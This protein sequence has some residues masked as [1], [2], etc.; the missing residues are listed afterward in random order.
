MDGVNGEQVSEQQSMERMKVLLAEPPAEESKR[1]VEEL[2]ENSLYGVFRASLDG[3]LLTA[4]PAM[5]Q[6]LAYPVLDELQAASLPREI[7]RFPA[8]F[9][10]LVALCRDNGIVP[11]A[12]AE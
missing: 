5:L 1:M 4:N 11:S 7:F 10:N 12:E 8:Q 6:M 9:G 2:I 3:R